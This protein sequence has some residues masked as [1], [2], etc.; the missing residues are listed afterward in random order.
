MGFKN[1]LAHGNEDVWT[2]FQRDIDH[3]IQYFQHGI[4]LLPCIIDTNI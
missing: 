2:V 3:N 1:G 4:S